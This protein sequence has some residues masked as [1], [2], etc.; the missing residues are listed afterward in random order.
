MHIEVLSLLPNYVEGPLQESILKRAIQHNLLRVTTRNIRD[1][2]SRKDRRV[3]DRPFGGGPGM[4]MMA[5]PTVAAIR[6]CRREHSRVIYLSPQGSLL[7][8]KRARELAALDHLILL[9]G[10]YEG[11]DQRA[12][13]SDVDEQLSIGD[14]VLTNGCL[15]ALVVIDVVARF[16]PGVL[17]HDDAA[18]QDS[19]EAGIFDHPHYTKPLVFEGKAVPEV[20]LGGDH[21]KINTWR[22]SQAYDRTLHVRP[23]LIA[24]TYC[25]DAAV[26][27]GAVTLKETAIFCSEFVRSCRFYER[28]LGVEPVID[29]QGE[30]AS[31]AL[32][33]TVFS[34]ICSETSSSHILSFTLSMGQF[35]RAIAWCRGREGAI[36]S[37]ID[38]KAVLVDPERRVVAISRE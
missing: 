8:P 24:K 35:E 3:D 16:I 34:L 30:K 25:S 12:I 4:V 36:A 38:T 23:E 17:G 33:N 11:I 1:F 31:F 6:A 21:A 10:H 9:C 22:R 26:S 27:G 5:E 7:T 18:T 19:F 29:S 2:S 28:V 20:L 15:A 13:E 37:L 14:Y 32:G